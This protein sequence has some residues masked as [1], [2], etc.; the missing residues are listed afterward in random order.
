MTIFKKEALDQINLSLVATGQ[1][2]T[3]LI[4]DDKESNLSVMSGILKADYHVLEARDGLEALALIENM[5]DRAALACI[6]SDYRMPRLNGVELLERAQLLVPDALRIIV[7]GFIDIDAIIDSINRGGIYKLIVKPFEVN[8]FL[9][10]AQGAVK[11]FEVQRDL[12]M[13]LKKLSHMTP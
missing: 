11:K 8:D 1:R 2:A 5:E 3:I 12:L 13:Q 9:T 7:T 4:V 6:I 10:A